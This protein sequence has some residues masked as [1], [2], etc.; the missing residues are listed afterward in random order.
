MNAKQ[1]FPF[2]SAP[3]AYSSYEDLINSDHIDAVYIP[4]PTGLRKEW[5][6]KAAQAKK[7]VPGRKAGWTQRHG[8]RTDAKSVRRQQG[9]VHGT[10]SCSCTADD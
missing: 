8:R 3:K 10:A 4:I 6:I 1:R 9:S 7:H 2:P 5:V